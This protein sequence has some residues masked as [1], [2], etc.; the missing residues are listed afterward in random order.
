[1]KQL[2]QTPPTWQKKATPLLGLLFI[3]SGWGYS[4]QAIAASVDAAIPQE[5]L[6]EVISAR[7]K[8]L[9][10]QEYAPPKNIEL[11]ALNN[12]DYQDYR[13]IRFKQDK[14]VWK[15]E[16]LYELQLF[17]PGFLY[18]TPVTINTVEG[19]SKRNRLPFILIF[20]NTMAQPPL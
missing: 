16:G 10:E 6:F 20:I 5:S 9:A 11:E 4:T 1:M 7:A 12:I 2:T 3:F 13:S 15:D 18:K 19:D 17:H 14:S 8:K